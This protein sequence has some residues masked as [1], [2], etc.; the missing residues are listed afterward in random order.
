MPFWD[1]LM[2]GVKGLY[3]APL[4]ID[5]TPSLSIFELRTKAVVW[6]GSIKSRL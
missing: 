5:D 6:S 3:S 1:K 2:S 4:Y